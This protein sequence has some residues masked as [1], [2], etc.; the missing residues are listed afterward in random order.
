VLRERNNGEV[1]GIE[2]KAAATVTAD[3]FRGLSFLQDKLGAQFK[4]GAAMDA[5]D[6]TLPF[7][8]R[9]TA[10]PIAGLWAH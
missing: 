7:G 4:S 1:V 9:L 10:V 3:D 2:V 5:G 6:K 8:D